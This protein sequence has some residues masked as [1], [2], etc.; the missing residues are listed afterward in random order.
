[1]LNSLMR[2]FL[3]II[4]FQFNLIFLQGQTPVGFW[5]DHLNYNIAKDLAASSESIFA[6]TGS[7]VLV[8]NKE[9]GE[10]RKLSRVNG[11]SETG[12]STLGWSEE[13]KTL[14]IAYSSTNIDLV[15]NN[16]IYNIPDISRKYIPGKKEINRIRTKGRYAYLACSFGIVVVDLLKEEIY[17]TWKPG[18]DKEIP[19]VWDIAFGNGKVIA[20]TGMGVFT[21]EAGDPGLS[22]F[23]NWTTENSLPDPSG[24]YSLAFFS[25]NKLYV[26]H[27]TVD[28]DTIFVIDS[29]CSFFSG[30]P[31]TVFTSFEKAGSG[32]SISTNNSV[33]YYNDGGSLLKSITSYG[34]G[35]PE[36]A[37]SFADNGDIWIADEVSG[38]IR[39]EN[40]SEFYSLRLPGPLS[41]NCVNITS[42]NGKTII[43]G[44]GIDASWDNIWRPLQISINQNNAW[45]LI[46]Y[47]GTYDPL[48]AIIDPADN[49]HFFVS[50][51]GG[52]LLEYR[53]NVLDNHFTYTNSP[54]QTIIPDRPFVR[55]CGMAID[56]KNNL[57]IT[58]T[59]V[60]GSFKV[61][62]PD[63]T[64]IE[65]PL[66]IAAPTIG[67]MII[68]QN[69][70]KWVV[71]PRG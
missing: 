64:W 33:N 27:S 71:L 23:G 63:G 11:L 31:G 12:I 53:N 16:T 70:Q 41:D 50:T 37:H 51:W 36:I 40:M 25:G 43:S 49:D 59:G 68:T 24:K 13:N 3:I 18:T 54:L 69:G 61:L 65:N 29:G 62:K 6:S 66:T 15:K 20:A 67:D 14:I 48:R 30:S 57:W 26:N 22:F 45:D 7:S 4:F 32:F 28:G 58:Q 35:V 39:G 9:F 8:Y 10:L 2:K 44:G 56:N 55:V 34:W 17:D 42:S 1:M 46:T 19:E 38:L 21:A 52:G 60:E 47:D 5:T